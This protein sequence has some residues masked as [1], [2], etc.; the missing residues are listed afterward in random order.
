MLTTDQPPGTSPVYRSESDPPLISVPFFLK[1]FFSAST[2][3]HHFHAESLVE[4][5]LLVRHKQ[6]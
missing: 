6:D 2:G 4:T 1:N 5:I 3:P